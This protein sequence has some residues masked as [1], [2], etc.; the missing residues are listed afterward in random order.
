MTRPRT[1]TTI[2]ELRT[3]LESGETTATALVEELDSKL[4]TA[5]E[6]VAF[7]VLELGRAYDTAA[8]W[9]RAAVPAAWL[10]KAA[11]SLL[12]TWRAS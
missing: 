7:R 10:P 11:D 6:K 9:D 2:A 12:K 1:L 3:R 8:A 4:V 5:P